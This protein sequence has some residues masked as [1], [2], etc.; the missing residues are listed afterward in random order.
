M[1][2]LRRE[3][4]ELLLAATVVLGDQ[5]TKLWILA[6]FAPY[7]QL[8]VISGLF[9]LVRVGNT[10]AAFGLLAGEQNSW[11]RLFFIVT[12]LVALGVILCI[13]RQL[14]SQNRLFGYALALIGGGAVGNLIDRVRFGFVVDFLDFYLGSSHWPAFN[15]ADSAISIGVGLIL[16]GTFADRKSAGTDGP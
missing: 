3:K 1:E 13:Y 6:V 7:E 11:R 15:V 4:F 12:T 10:G 16:L 8:P 14:K 5:L 9:N 2:I